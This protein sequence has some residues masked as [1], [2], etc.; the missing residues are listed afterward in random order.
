MNPHEAPHV[1]PNWDDTFA[2]GEVFTIE[3]GLYG[4]ALRHG[5]RLENDYL[6]TEAGVELLTPFP[7]GLDE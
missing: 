6:V 5:I 3:P 1:N 2:A 4:D 7:L